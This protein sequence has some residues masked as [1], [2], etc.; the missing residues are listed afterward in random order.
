MSRLL[1]RLIQAGRQAK[2]DAQRLAEKEKQNAIERKLQEEAK[3][4]QAVAAFEQRQRL[5]EV[6]EV[7]NRLVDVATYRQM[8]MPKVK[9]VADII[10]AH[11][12]DHQP[13]SDPASVSYYVQGFALSP[14]RLF[15]D[16]NMRV[17]FAG[18]TDL[19][20]QIRLYLVVNSY[21]R[22]R[23]RRWDGKQAYGDWYLETLG[24]CIGEGEREMPL[25]DINDD[26]AIERAK[27]T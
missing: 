17:Y 7:R 23:G 18:F 24:W 21:K 16:D 3:R 6:L 5:L 22:E 11:Y 25:S 1:D 9:L 2:V 10:T 12:D 15:V 26:R 20:W 27:N 19:G 13:D 4:A 14:N 8:I